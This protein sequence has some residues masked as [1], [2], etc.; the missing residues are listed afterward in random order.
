MYRFK[1]GDYV[2][3]G[4]SGACEVVDIGKLDFGSNDKI[5]YTLQPYYDSRDKIYVPVDREAEIIRKVI[6]KKEAEKRLPTIKK[7]RKK[8]RIPAREEFDVI[9]K[10]GDMDNVTNLIRQLREVKHE[11]KKNHKSLNIADAKMLTYAE[12]M[13]Y[14]EMAIAMGW[15]MDQAVAELSE[16]LG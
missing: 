4:V 15:T 12:R 2:L 6:E 1:V 8:G 13:L 5:Y 16:C 14:S 7:S 11:N 10:S 9:L 3:Y